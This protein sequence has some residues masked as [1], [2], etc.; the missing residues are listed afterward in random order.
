MARIQRQ[1]G[2]IVGES[3][4]VDPRPLKEFERCIHC[5]KTDKIHIKVDIVARNYCAGTSPF[6]LPNEPANHLAQKLRTF[7]R[8]SGTYVPD[9][10]VNAC[11]PPL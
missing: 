4:N 11:L 3:I 6:L 9:I 7:A 2:A 8:P 10:E 5:S 1:W